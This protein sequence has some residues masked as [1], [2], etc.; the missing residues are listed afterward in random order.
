MN[1][2]QINEKDIPQELLD[3][4][5]SKFEDEP[6]IRNLRIRQELCAR[7]GQFNAAFA[8]GAEINNLFADVVSNYL[9]DVGQ[10][11]E[12]IDLK[13]GDL[14]EEGR[15]ELVEI[16]LTLILATDIID[17]AAKDFNIVLHRYDKTMDIVQFDDICKLAK[18][19]E[20][21]LEWFSERS[22]YMKYISFGEKSDN[23]YVM[24]RNKARSF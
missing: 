13:V 4:I 15:D 6:K 10:E 12:I 23:M 20:G 3:I 1:D 11:Y 16:M 24:L 21:K 2:Y 7:R 8:I 19:I 17:T 18:E 22:K 5:K 9:E 14:P